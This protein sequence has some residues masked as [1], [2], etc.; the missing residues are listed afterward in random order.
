MTNFLQ[1]N[2]AKLFAV[3]AAPA[4]LNAGPEIMALDNEMTRAT[5]KG[6]PGVYVLVEFFSEQDKAAG[7]DERTF[8]TDVEV[9]L[10]LVGIKALT[11]EEQLATPGMPILYLHVNTLHKQPGQNHVY[12]ISLGLQQAVR[13][14]RNGALAY[15][16]RTWGVNSV[17]YGDLPFIRNAVKDYVDPIYQCLAECEF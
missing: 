16:A 9:K 17:G 7:F 8:Q 4:L 10:R 2:F 12:N 5:L 6:L 14:V 1:T 15:G 3:I 13:L 11:E